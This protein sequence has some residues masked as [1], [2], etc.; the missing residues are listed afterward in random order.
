MKSLVG[1]ELQHDGALI[2]TFRCAFCGHVT[3]REFRLT[4]VDDTVVC[5]C[6]S[7]VV[8]DRLSFATLQTQVDS[9]RWTVKE[10]MAD[11]KLKL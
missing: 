3:R 7:L 2:V 4:R 5:T 9:L 11:F 1:L 10:A 8:L 6:G